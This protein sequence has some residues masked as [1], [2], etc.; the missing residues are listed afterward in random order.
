M[1]NVSHNNLEGSIPQEVGNVKNLMEFHA[2]SNKLTGEIPSTLGECQVLQGLYLQNNFLSGSI[3]SALS[4]LKGLQS[5]DLSSNNL[6][7]QIP[8]FLGDITML[9]SLNL[10]FNN[11]VG[12]VPTLGVFANVSR[13]SIKGNGKLCGGVPNLHLPPCSV[14]LPKKKHKF[15][16]VSMLI[17]V[18]AILLILASIYKLLAWY[19]KN[20]AHIPSAMLVQHHPFISYS[21]LVKATDGFSTS[22]LLG[23]GSFGCVY[24]GKLEDNAGASTSTVAVKVLK[25]QTPGALRSFTAE[26]EALRNLRHRNLVTIITVCSSIDNMGN[27]FKAIVYD[28]MPRGSLEGWLHVDRNDQ[29]EGRY[30]NLLERV[31]ILLDV[32]YALDYLHCHGPQPVVHCD[33]KSSNV[34]LDADM[35]AHV[36]DF[37]LS[38]ILVQ[39][40]SLLQQSTGSMGFRGTIGYAAPG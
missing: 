36:G 9:Y 10:S 25:L 37:G 8:K 5:L 28:F 22:N 4:Q 31:T 2:E 16:V 17:P 15:L 30:L 23:S 40:I 21:Q 38:K 39:E 11:F 35:V 26:C 29:A 12:E 33:L 1:F 18:V 3:P 24:K 13:I 14:R 34:L 19:K 7:G 20:K 6:S 27:D 32:G